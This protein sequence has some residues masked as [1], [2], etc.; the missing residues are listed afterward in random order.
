MT[1]LGTLSDVFT[2]YLNSDTAQN[3]INIPNLPDSKMTSTPM[4][5]PKKLAP[6]SPTQEPFYIV[7]LK[8]ITSS[9][10]STVKRTSKT[11]GAGY[12]QT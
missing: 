7:F 2:K 1:E 4:K 12:F 5:V 3:T 10:A 9:N 6:P 11:K 8:S